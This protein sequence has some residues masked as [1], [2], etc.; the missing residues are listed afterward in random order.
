MY[1]Y[2]KI[3]L[4]SALL[5]LPC[6]TFA[7]SAV[8]DV[9]CP[10]IITCTNQRC[11]PIPPKFTEWNTPDLPNGK[12]YFWGA[13]GQPSICYYRNDPHPQQPQV[14]FS[15]KFYN[16]D[17]YIPNKWNYSQYSGYSCLT[18]DPLNCPFYNESVPR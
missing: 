13:R 5:A 11:T 9:T 17:I 6:A 12:Y 2:T 15:S 7:M 1:N 14:Q 16:V 18:T 4:L 3:L 10:Q 8:T